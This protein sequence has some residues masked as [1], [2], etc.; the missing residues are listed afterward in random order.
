MGKWSDLLLRSLW[1]RTMYSDDIKYIS[2][3][4]VI[5]KNVTLGI[6]RLK[7][8]LDQAKTIKTPSNTIRFY[9]RGVKGS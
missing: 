7:E 4:G 5:S 8:L 3:C 2:F 9:S 6:P 1:K